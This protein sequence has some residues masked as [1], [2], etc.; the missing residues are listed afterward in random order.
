MSII[1]FKSSSYEDILK[2]TLTY[3]SNLDDYSHKWKDYYEGGAGTT[4]AELISALGT[5]LNY[6]AMMNR[7]ESYLESARLRS[8]LVNMSSMLG[9]DINR[10]K[11]GTVRIKISSDS[12]LEWSKWTP[13]GYYKDNP[14]HPLKDTIIPAGESYVDVV[15]GEW[16]QYKEVSKTSS[17]FA[18]ILIEDNVDN[19]RYELKIN[20]ELVEIVRNAEELDEK[21]V[22]MRTF[23]D[24]LFLIFCDDKFGR[25]L[26]N[27]DE[28]EFNYVVPVTN[29]D[30]TQLTTDLN[31]YS[32]VHGTFLSVEIINQLSSADSNEKLRALASGY[33][34]TVK[35]MITVNDHVYVTL[36]YP[37]IISANAQK[38]P[39][40]CCTVYVSYLHE[41]GKLS[42]AG[43]VELYNYLTQ[44][45][46]LGTNIILVDPVEKLVDVKM[47]VVVKDISD[48]TLIRKEITDYVQSLTKKL[49]GQFTLSA[50]N[51]MNFDS[52][53]RIY[54]KYPIADKRAA[55]NEYFE[56][57]KLDI[58]FTTNYN[59]LESSGTDKDLGYL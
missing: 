5:Y 54:I 25:K 47:L 13:I 58:E 42:D 20:G 2:D 14:I 52:L 10:A 37:G 59:I 29:D 6:T 40:K 38:H 27:L 4:I 7:R 17:N 1:D 33:Y 30:I 41:K 56:I 31:D 44:Y 32:S 53:I 28:I 3:V 49:G 34:S 46:L 16:K 9:Y 8:S 57:N 36:G 35:R 22:L 39:T 26:N 15:I 12:Q 48:T 55:Y 24:G 45:N 18:R 21:K 19:D 11:A 50:L 23:N 51:S 43:K